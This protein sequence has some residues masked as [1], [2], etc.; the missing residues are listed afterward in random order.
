MD[1]NIPSKVK[2]FQN[3]DGDASTCT[4]AFH[5]ANIAFAEKTSLK[6]RCSTQALTI[7]S[8][9]LVDQAVIA[10]NQNR[11]QA[12]ISFVSQCRPKVKPLANCD[13]FEDL[14]RT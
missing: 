8:K 13:H 3:C 9:F 11:G 4:Q 7:D 14:R 6:P 2:S 12:T 5:P 1:P 10:A